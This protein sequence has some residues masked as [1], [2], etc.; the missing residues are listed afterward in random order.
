[1][2]NGLLEQDIDGLEQRIGICWT[3][4]YIDIFDNDIPDRIYILNLYPS[5][6]KLKKDYTLTD[7]CIL[8]A[9]QLIALY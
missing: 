9:K 1:M 6:L 8:Q 3:Y 5:N 2:R 4:V 7:I